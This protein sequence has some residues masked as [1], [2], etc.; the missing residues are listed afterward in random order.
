[1]AALALLQPAPAEPAAAILPQVQAPAPPPELREQDMLLF[2]VSLDRLTLT[3]SL[4]AYGDPADPLLP[5]GELA[6]LLDLDLAVMPR[7]RRIVGT[8]GEDRRAVTVDFDLPLLRVGGRDIPFR[9]ADVG[10]TATDIFV[11][12]S[13]I[14][15]MLPVRL[16]IDGEALAIEIAALE[17]LPIQARW[18]R[19]GRLQDLE[20]GAPEAGAVMRI[21]TPYRLFSPPSFD[22][23]LE[24]GTDTRQAGDVRRRYDIRFAGDLLYSNVQG[25]VGADDTGEPSTVRLLF[26]RRSVERNLPLGATRIGVGDV[27]TPTLALGPRSVNGRGLAFSTAPLDQASLLNT[28]DLRGELPIGYDVELYVNDIL[29]SGQRT[30]VE[31]RYE[32]LN[33]PLVSGINVI[34]IVSYGPRGDRSETVRVV[35]AGGGVIPRGQTVF[36]LGAVEQERALIEPVRFPGQDSGIGAPGALRLVAGFAHGLTELVTLVGGAAVYSSD[37]KAERS[38]VTAGVR[39]SLAGAAVQADLAADH[40][41]GRALAAGAAGEFLG[42]SAYVRHA[43]YRGGFVDE[44]VI[45]SDLTRP[46]LRNTVVTLDFSMPFFDGGAV[47]LS[48]R[49]LRDGYRDGGIAWAGT[50]RASTSIAHTL[51]STGL[52]YR[53]ES[54][55]GVP[56]FEQLTGNLALSRLVDYDWQLRAAAD[57]DLLPSSTLRAVGA[58]VDYG[59]SERLSLRAGYGQTF[60]AGRD[61]AFQA[62]AVLRL[63]FA[64]LSLT[65]DYVTRAGDWRVALQLSFGALF[66]PG[67]RRYVMTPPGAAAG[68]NLALQAFIDS[69]GDGRFGPGDEPA[70]KVVVEGGLGREVTGAE[71]RALVTGLGTAPSAQVRVDITEVDNFYLVA[72]PPTIDF[73]PRAGQV[74]AVPYPLRP[75]G[76]VYVRVY[77]LRAEGETG[78]SAL[79]LRLVRDG[80]PPITALSEF[81]GSVV[82]SG[83]PPGT[84]RLELDP[85]QAERLRMRLKQPVTLA[86]LADGALDIASEVIF[87][88]EAP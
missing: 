60:G 65:G 14:E 29:R 10:Y 83:I 30:P 43:E 16:A 71:G 12:A 47:P 70:P 55:P 58:T 59:L 7:E 42:V 8:L 11:R 63:P 69:D 81:D 54:R 75:A 48:M 37:R 46:P 52:D 74:V 57:F 38:M 39:A 19:L 64:D 77:L 2:A 68:A 36:T 1:M 40:R 34:R 80:E 56:A 4:I 31:G 72:P 73:E 62:G 24:T 26:E 85:E 13:V 18:E 76:E 6:R 23:I 88:P 41:G 87:E 82:F 3:D 25:Y 79:R 53:R 32:F 17:E 50:A 86:V 67:R 45:S 66:D 61:S 51:V 27:F 9:S 28:I 78:L 49:V 22:A 44:T 5:V 21:E 20:R 15:G 84:Y 35:N 33:V